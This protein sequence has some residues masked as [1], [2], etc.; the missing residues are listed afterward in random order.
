VAAVAALLFGGI[1]GAG[2]ASAD[3]DGGKGHS[4]HGEG[5]GYGHDKN[6]GNCPGNEPDGGGGHGDGTEVGIGPIVEADP[7]APWTDPATPTDGN[8]G[9]DGNTGGGDVISI[10]F[11]S[12]SAAPALGGSLTPGAPTGLTDLI[13]PLANVRTDA[14][15]RQGRSLPYGWGTGTM[16]L[17][18]DWPGYP[19]E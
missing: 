14:G 6:H 12:I 10:P 1:A 5:N 9:G 17:P 15:D 3:V 19:T 2:S 7:V 8:G 16:A 4:K 11:G 13:V 18:I